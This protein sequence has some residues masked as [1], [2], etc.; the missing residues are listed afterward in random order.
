MTDGGVTEFQPY[1][2]GTP[3]ED[4]VSRAIQDTR[5]AIF[6]LHGLGPNG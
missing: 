6:P 3:A 2:P 1:A 5:A 4:A